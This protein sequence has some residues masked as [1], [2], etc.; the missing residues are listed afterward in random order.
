MTYAGKLDDRV[1]IRSRVLT[2]NE[3]GEQE[4]TYI[5]LATVWAEV[6]PTSGNERFLSAAMYANA[7]LK[8]RIRYRADFDETAQ[9]LW[10][11][12]TWE[13]IHIADHRRKG[14]TMMLVKKPA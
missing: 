13:I 11:G 5:D 14:E 1:T 2:G 8:I 12:Q 9:V 7:Q 6:T 4:V 10:D 3:F